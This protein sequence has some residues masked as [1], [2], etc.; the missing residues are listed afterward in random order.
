MKNRISQHRS[1]RGTTLIELIAVV[2]II[3]VLALLIVPNIP[4]VKRIGEDSQMKAKASQLNGAM[5]SYMS[6]QPM[7][8]AIT[9]WAAKDNEGRYALVQPY[10]QF[11][12]PTLAQFCV[13]GFTVTF[14]TDPRGAVTV[15][16]PDGVAVPY[17]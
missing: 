16:D 8:L 9:T 12:T 3:G 6:D 11:A 1:N 10:L 17:Q 2:V 14:P 4:A 7:R 5:V 15:T 13:D